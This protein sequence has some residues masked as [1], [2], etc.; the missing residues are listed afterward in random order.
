MHP[1]PPLGQRA[2]CPGHHHDQRL[3]RF[4]RVDDR[5]QQIATALEADPGLPGAAGRPG[6]L[7]P[8]DGIS[9][10]AG[11]AGLVIGDG[12]MIEACAPGVPV[13][14]A[15][16]AGRHPAGFTHPRAQ[17]RQVR[18]GEPSLLAGW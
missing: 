9:D 8:A 16:C 5:Q 11:H 7:R 6:V 3:V 1:E 18:A 13:R 4:G 14:V 17:R 12:K 15:S 2:I 10:A